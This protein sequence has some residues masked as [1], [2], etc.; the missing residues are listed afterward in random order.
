MTKNF[1]FVS[2][3]LESMQMCSRNIVKPSLKLS[4]PF[5]E[6]ISLLRKNTIQ[7][8]TKNCDSIYIV[9]YK[10]SLDK[11]TFITLANVISRV[12][13]RNVVPHRTES[14]HFDAVLVAGVV[15]LAAVPKADT[16]R[17]RRVRVVDPLAF[18][19]AI[20]EAEPDVPGAEL[21]INRNH[22][23]VGDRRGDDRVVKTAIFNGLVEGDGAAR[24]LGVALV[25][26]EVD[27]G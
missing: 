25:Q 21:V 3:S 12:V 27:P 6:T 7:Y 9:I 14:E 22:F 26:G 15:R 24:A 13:T 8:T 11:R 2:S 4:S 18:D 19:V 10:Y 5:I 1:Q 23:V 20:G 17:S 16:D